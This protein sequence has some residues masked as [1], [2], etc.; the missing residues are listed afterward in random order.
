MI[1]SGWLGWVIGLLLLATM[2]LGTA[3]TGGALL[4]AQGEENLLFAGN[5]YAAPFAN[6]H[7]YT[8]TNPYANSDAITFS[9]TT[10]LAPN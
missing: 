8:H 2:V 9:H 6:P 3:V 5:I 10:A 4:G 7:S 1:R